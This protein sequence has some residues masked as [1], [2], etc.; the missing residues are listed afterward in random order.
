MS[1]VEYLATPEKTPHNCGIFGMYLREEMADAIPRS[2]I[3]LIALQHR[4]Q[5]GAGAAITDAYGNVEM[6]KGSGLVKRVLT[7]E[8][9]GSLKTQKPKMIVEQTR[10]STSGGENAWQP[11]EEEGLVLV[12]NGN[13]TNPRDLLEQ[14]PSSLQKK[15]ESDSWIIHQSILQEFRKT[16][17]MKEAIINV[18]EQC[19]GAYNLII[20]GEGKMF[21][22]RDPKGFHPMV[23]G[24]LP[25]GKGHV[26]ASEPTALMKAGAR[27]IRPINPGEGVVIDDDGV[28][29]FFMDER[30]DLKNLSQCLFELIYFA[31]PDSKIFGRYGTEVR[32]ELGKSLARKD[33]AKGFLPDIIV[34]I[35]HSGRF[36]GEGYAQEMQTILLETPELFGLTDQEARKIV[37]TLQLQT[38]LIVNAD[39][40]RS[41]IMPDGQRQDIIS[42][43]HRVDTHALAGKRV[44]LIDDSIV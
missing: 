3:G 27:Y 28:H 24:E 34:P 39:A 9:I 6:I 15:A 13:F 19:D 33:A 25:D 41:F 36:A 26:L 8:A 20:S 22:I 31:S 1:A 30:T 32:R 44:A 10:Y 17:N 14:L 21:G 18:V 16:R 42:T 37:P 35:E 23:L 11:Y 2:V 38:A 12:H 7:P 4:G 5:E 40:I 43:K 29:T